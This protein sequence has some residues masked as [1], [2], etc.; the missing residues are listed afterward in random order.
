MKS[1]SRLETALTGVEV[2]E[3]GW[4]IDGENFDQFL[5]QFD[6]AADLCQD[7]AAQGFL[8]EMPEKRD[9]ERPAISEFHRLLR[10]AF[11]DVNEQASSDYVIADP[12][13]NCLFV[14][15]CWKHG[16]AGTQGELNRL[17][18]NAR[19]AKK[20]G[21]IPN[22]KR[23]V[24]SRKT[25]EQYE[26]AS[27]VAVRLLQDKVFHK[28]GSWVS[29]DD[30]LCEPKLGR[31]FLGIA[32]SITPGFQE[33]DYRWAAL[34]IRKAMNTRVKREDLERPVFTSLGTAE[35]FFI[36]SVPEQAG[37]FRM[38]RSGVVFYIGH[39]SNL[40][41]KVSSMIAADLANKIENEDSKLLFP[42]E[43]LDY[44][45]APAPSMPISHR[46]ELK[47][48]IVHENAPLLNITKHMDKRTA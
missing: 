2:D 14:Q 6:S 1:L 30:I 28:E 31:R 4:P 24:V 3:Y 22:V 43:P 23:Y 45:I 8:F 18:M 21:K 11:L 7:R 34:S 20:L 27:E 40:R 35:S 37:F 48:L 39:A 47:K 19:K 29:L 26:F 13:K 32:E 46:F 12:K 41:F 42:S 5:V 25:M 16:I 33:L 9:E 44:S 10:S 38:M 17:L 15:S 36:D